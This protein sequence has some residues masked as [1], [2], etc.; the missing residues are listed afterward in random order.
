MEVA[1]A[2][3]K[4]R[5]MLVWIVP[6]TSGLRAIPCTAPRAER[7]TPMPP[8]NTPTAAKPAPMSLPKMVA[9]ST[10]LPSIALLPPCRSVRFGLPVAGCGQG[11]KDQREHAEYDGLD[12]AHEPLEQEHRRLHE[13]REQTADHEEQDRAGEDVAEKSERERKHLHGFQDGFQDADHE[14]NHTEHRAGEQ[15]AGVHEFDRIAAAQCPQPDDLGR[16]HRDDCQGN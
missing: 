13:H 1:S 3:A 16:Y 7:P 8:P 2:K 12:D 14:V 4:P 5:I 6:V 15:R 11:H 9:A 10:M